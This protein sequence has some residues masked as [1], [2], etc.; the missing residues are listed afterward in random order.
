MRPPH[1]ALGRGRSHVRY[2]WALIERASLEGGRGGPKPAPSVFDLRDD[3]VEG[4]RTRESGVGR[5]VEDE[6]LNLDAPGG[7]AKPRA[8][9]LD[10]RLGVGRS[11][12]VDRS[13]R[14]HASSIQ[15]QRG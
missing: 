12:V 1:R 5:I 2:R 6:R 8:T 11:A 13:D 10:E 9:H 4:D 3:Y 14:R 15:P 7:T